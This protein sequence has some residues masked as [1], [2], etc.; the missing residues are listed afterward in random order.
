[1]HGSFFTSSMSITIAPSDLESGYSQWTQNR[2][3]QQKN[4]GTASEYT[5]VETSLF[6]PRKTPDEET[7]LLT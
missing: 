3:K 5:F 7:S 4:A 2:S 6:H 1:M